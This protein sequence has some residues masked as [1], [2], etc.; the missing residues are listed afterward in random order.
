VRMKLG[1]S[2]PHSGSLA[3]DLADARSKA[4]GMATA[5]P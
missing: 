3:A 2:A 4:K 1:Q 5:V